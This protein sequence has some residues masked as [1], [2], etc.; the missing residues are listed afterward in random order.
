MLKF[1]QPQKAHTQHTFLI[2][3]DSYRIQKLKWFKTPTYTGTR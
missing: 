3:P 1:R 2:I